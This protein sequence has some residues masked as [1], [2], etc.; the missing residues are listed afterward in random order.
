MLQAVCVSSEYHSSKRDRGTIGIEVYRGKLRLRLPRE[1]FRGK[2]KA[3]Y[4]RL[5]DT[6]EGR[7]EATKLAWRIEDDISRDSFDPTLAKY[8]A[9]IKLIASSSTPARSLLELWDKY[10][11]YRRPQLSITHY[12]ENY[13]KRYRNAILELPT[14]S[15]TAAVEVRDHI[16]QHKSPGTAKQLLIQFNA[17][18]QFGVKSNLITHNPFEGMA[19]DIKVKSRHYQD[20]DPF[21]NA[22]RDAIIE[23]FAAHPHYQHYTNFVKFLF[24]TGC[25]TSEAV[26][27]RWSDI[28]PECTIV[29]FTSVITKKQ[30][31]STKTNRTRR[32][33][34][35][36]SLT[37][38]LQSIRSEASLPDTLVFPNPQGNPINPATFL[39]NAWGGDKSKGHQGIVS[40]LVTQGLVERYRP[41]YNTRHTFITTCLEAGISI[42]QIARWVGNSPSTLLAYYGG[43]I[44]QMRPPEF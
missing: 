10:S 34:C 21:S 38:L 28:N 41:Q 33:P 7:K 12:E 30:R 36:S 39:H 9:N 32:F 14:Q 1:L 22:E 3:I 42:P 6:L 19:A 44:R 8:Q 20:I 13:R 18:C 26:G 5:P 31:K 40:E 43:V 24:L 35:N 17:A 29:S 2:Q 11:E 4:T 37:T 16:V 15:L 27:L 23:A 25:R